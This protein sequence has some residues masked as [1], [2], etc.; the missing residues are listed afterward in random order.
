ME[1]A[2]FGEA[3]GVLNE[4]RGWLGGAGWGGSVVR[5]GGGVGVG[6]GGGGVRW[7][8]WG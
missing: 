7:V 3:S 2:A 5:D 1:L 8:G 4:Y 6:W